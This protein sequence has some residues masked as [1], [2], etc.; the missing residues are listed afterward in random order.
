MVDFPM[1]SP[2]LAS[3]LVVASYCL[4]EFTR[5]QHEDDLRYVSFA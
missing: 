3:K 5:R 4:G 2:L 1:L